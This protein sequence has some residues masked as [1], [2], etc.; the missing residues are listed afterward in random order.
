M[1]RA[2][3]FIIPL[4]YGENTDWYKNLQAIG[5]IELQWQGVNYL[6]GKPELL[7]VSSAMK[8]FPL[9]SRFL[10]WLDGLPAFV[11]VAILS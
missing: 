10:F 4:T 11:Q 3:Q 1:K 9:I 7:E 5:S 2:D 8:Y 6:V